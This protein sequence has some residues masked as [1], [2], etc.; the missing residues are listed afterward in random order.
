MFIV[1]IR[2]W[3]RRVESLLA[4]EAFVLCMRPKKQSGDHGTNK[5]SKVVQQAVVDSVYQIEWHIKS[6][7]QASV[8]PVEDANDL[9]NDTVVAL[10]QRCSHC[11]TVPNPKYAEQ[12]ARSQFYSGKRKERVRKACEKIRTLSDEDPAKRWNGKGVHKERKSV[13][14]SVVTKCDHGRLEKALD[15]TSLTD[16]E[17]IELYFSQRKKRCEVAAAL[18]LSNRGATSRLRRALGRLTKGVE[19]IS[20]S[21]GNT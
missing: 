8:N 13:L 9:F 5:E 16:R 2:G 7:T 6:L 19:K 21:M 10:L 14:D 20:E 4:V 1:F 15:E 11:G 18:G 12:T 17:V 3:P